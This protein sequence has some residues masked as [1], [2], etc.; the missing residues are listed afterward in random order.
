MPGL[1]IYSQCDLIQFMRDHS[2]CWKEKCPVYPTELVFAL[3]QSYDAT[4]TRFMTMINIIRSIIN[5]LYIMENNCPVGA[6]VT[7]V[8]F[9]SHVHYL[10]RGFDYH[11]KEQLLQLLSQIR[12]QPPTAAQDIG[13]AMRFVAR[14]TFKRTRGGPNM[15]RVA[16][17]FSNGQAADLSS[18][19]T[20]T[21]EFSAWDISPAV[22]AINERVF[23]DE[24]FEF[25]NTG[26]FQVI[27]VPPRWAR[28]HIERFRRCTLCY[29]KCF[30][31]DCA[32]E[33]IIPEDTYIDVALLVESS[34]NVVTD[35]YKAVK[36]LVSTMLDN[37]H[38]SSAPFTPDGDRIA[39][40]SYSPWDS[41]RIRK[42]PMKIEFDFTSF[43]NKFL[44]QNYIQTQLQ[45]LSGEATIGHTLTWI[46]E[47]LF[48]RTPSLR[49]HKV[50]FVVSAGEN[51][52]RKEFLQKIALKAKCQ[53]FII[54]VI[55]LGSASRG[56]VE[57]LASDPP[58]HH[59]I[60]LGRIHKPDL[61]YIVRFLKPFVHSIRRGFNQYPPQAPELDC[62]LIDMEE[63]EDFPFTPEPPE[64][65]S[66]E[67]SFLHQELSGRDSSMVLED[68]GSDHLVYIPSHLRMPQEINIKY[69]KDH[70]SSEVSSFTSD[71][72]DVRWP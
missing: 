45:H 19:I 36:T 21:M 25:D 68:N 61:D 30:P 65:I 26:T 66:G 56:Y 6:R 20:A 13:N 59:L 42:G 5:E 33:I 22:L 63:K 53:G 29:D 28:E 2:P 57:E 16:V 60:R 70:H 9:D 50:I 17:F 67:N 37:F 10:I 64:F 27:T 46:A 72:E 38:I 32:K 55:S 40:L 35:D 7:L 3:D 44:M 34:S 43:N 41:S 31:N 62:R 23:P 48:P 4:E 18:V 15:R 12:Y 47:N 1:P 54:V 14:N 69:K 52:E 51:Y 49:K 71:G 58:D 39:L 11:R 8:A 24:V